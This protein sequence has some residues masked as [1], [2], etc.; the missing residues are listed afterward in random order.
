MYTK[1]RLIDPPWDWSFLDLLSGDFLNGYRKVGLF[2][3]RRVNMQRPISAKR[4]GWEGNFTL[5]GVL[6]LG[7]QGYFINNFSFSSE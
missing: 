6:N 1:L 7:K 5:I 3:K 4:H 2:R